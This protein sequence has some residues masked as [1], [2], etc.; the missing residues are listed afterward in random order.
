MT[1]YTEAAQREALVRL[2]DG[3]EWFVTYIPAGTDGWLDAIICGYDY[4]GE[5]QYWNINGTA[6][7]ADADIVEIVK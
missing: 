7:S 4:T 1:D 6:L 3:S 2:A 5:Y